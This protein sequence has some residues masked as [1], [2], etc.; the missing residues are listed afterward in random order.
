MR[1][2]LEAFDILRMLHSNL[3][4]P[5]SILRLPHF[6]LRVSHPFWVCL[7]PFW[8]HLIP[9]FWCCLIPFWGCLIPFWGCLITFWGCYFTEYLE[10]PTGTLVPPK[11]SKFEDQIQVRKLG[12]IQHLQGQAHFVSWKG[13]QKNS[14]FTEETS[15][16]ID[17]AVE[18][19]DDTLEGFKVISFDLNFKG[20]NYLFTVKNL[21]DEKIKLL[22]KIMFFNICCRWQWQC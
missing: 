15:F 1:N 9:S 3:R 22:K 2:W 11:I 5:H 12:W 20:M 10:L 18:A 16:T 6:N 4:L 14:S 17:A 21:T 19:S 8:D 7:I 13:C